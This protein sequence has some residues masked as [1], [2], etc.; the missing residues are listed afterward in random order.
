[1]IGLILISIVSVYLLCCNFLFRKVE[2]VLVRNLFA[3][4]VALFFTFG[5]ICI[6]ETV[7]VDNSPLGREINFKSTS[8]AD[9]AVDSLARTLENAKRRGEENGCKDTCIVVYTHSQGT[10]LFRRAFDTLK[11]MPGFDSGVLGKIVFCGY[12]GETGIH[13]DEFGLRG[14]ENKLNWGDYI[15]GPW[16]RRLGDGRIPKSWKKGHRVTDYL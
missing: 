8:L 9:I 15:V 7:L 5:M 13:A 16:I 12:G 11:Y 14:A 2:H 1:M 3:L 4:I 10:M 6:L